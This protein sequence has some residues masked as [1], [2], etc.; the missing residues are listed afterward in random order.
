MFHQEVEPQ[1]RTM[2]A[3]PDGTV[4][5]ATITLGRNAAGN[6]RPCRRY[7]ADTLSELVYQDVWGEASAVGGRPARGLVHGGRA[8]RRRW[9]R[10][11]V[12]ARRLAVCRQGP[13]RCG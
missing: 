13:R 9:A 12:P 6:W 4:I 10:P 1:L 7:G 2:L 11:P 3:V 5:S 8:R